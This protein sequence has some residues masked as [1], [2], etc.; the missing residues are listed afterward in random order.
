MLI[1]ESPVGAQVENADIDVGW[2]QAGQGLDNDEQVL[3][4]R[5]WRV[6]DD[7]SIWVAANQDGLRM[8]E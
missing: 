3:V 5:F 6:Q 1:R 4:C 8:R 2:G 7:V